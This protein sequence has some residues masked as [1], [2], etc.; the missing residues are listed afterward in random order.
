M[1]AC[2]SLWILTYTIGASQIL[3]YEDLLQSHEV[4]KFYYHYSKRTG[5]EE[6]RSNLWPDKDRGEGLWNNLEWKKVSQTMSSLS[7]T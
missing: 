4:S 1:T 5:D 3:G 6:M 7:L 2:F